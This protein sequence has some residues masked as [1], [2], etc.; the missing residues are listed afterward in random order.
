MKKK[1]KKKRRNIFFFFFFALWRFLLL[2][3]PKVPS[4]D[5]SRR[6]LSLSLCLSVCVCV[7]DQKARCFSFENASKRAH[8]NTHKK[9]TFLCA[10]M[11]DMCGILT[12]FFKL[13]TTKNTK[14]VLLV[15]SFQTTTTTTNT[16][17][18]C[19]D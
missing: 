13:K 10:H 1:K 18:V 12:F 11:S 14:H 7:S 15:N 3:P 19:D 16:Q 5:I 4:E 9:L 8:T 6:S 2:L 17:L